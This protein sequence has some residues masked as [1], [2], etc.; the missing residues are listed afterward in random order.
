MAT[1]SIAEAL[2]LHETPEGVRRFSNG[3]LQAAIESAMAELGPDDHVAIV[4][5]QIYDRDGDAIENVTLLSSVVRLKPGLSVMVA[6]YKDW[7]KG[8]LGAEG[9]VVWKPW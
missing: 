5:H 4:A 6:G 8:T 7:T 2:A 9:R 1:A 3:R